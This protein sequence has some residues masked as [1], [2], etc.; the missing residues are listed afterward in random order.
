MSCRTYFQRNLL[1]SSATTLGV[2]CWMWCI[3]AAH[4][5][6]AA[7]Q[8]LAEVTNVSTGFGVPINQFA[9]VAGSHTL[10]ASQSLTAAVLAGATI[11]TN[12]PQL[13]I[14]PTYPADQQ[15]GVSNPPYMSNNLHNFQLS[16]FNNLFNFRG[17]HT[18]SS[19]DY[20]TVHGFGS[21]VEYYRNAGTVTWEPA[22]TRWMTAIEP[23]WDTLM[24]ALGLP[25]G[26]WD[27][28]VDTGETKVIQAVINAGYFNGLDPAIRDQLMIDME[29]WALDPTTLRQQ[30]WYPS[31]ASPADKAAFEKKYYDGYALTQYGPLDAAR[32]LGFKNISLYGWRPA[33]RNNDLAA[34]PKDP[35]ADWYWQNVGIQV[36]SH[37]D[38]IN[39]SV[40]VGDWSARN[41]AYTLALNDLNL[42]Y[43]KSLPTAQRK[44]LRPYFSNQIFSGT[45]AWRWFAGQGV[46]TEEMRAESLLNAFTQYDGMVLWNWSGTANDNLPPI[47]ATGID[48]MVKDGSF[49]AAREGG[50][51]QGFARYDALHVTNVDSSG[52][53][54]F[55]LIDKSSFPNYGTGAAFPFYDSTVTAM[56][57]HLRAQSEPLAGLFEGLAMAKLIEWNLRN[58]IPLV[59]FASQQTFDQQLPI[60]RHLTNGDLHIVATYDPQVVYGQPARNVTVNNFNAVAG[61]SLTF[62]ADSQVRLYFVKVPAATV[63]YW[64][65]DEGSGTTTADAS[66]N[67]NRGTLL[68]APAWTA[69]QTGNA[70]NFSASSSVAINGAGNLANLYKT[71]MTVAAWIKPGA[72]SAGGRIA[73]KDNNN[74]GWFFGMSNAKVQFVADQFIPDGSVAAAAASRVSAGSTTLNTWQHVVATWDGTTNA[75]NIHI[76]INGVLSDGAAVNGSGIADLD[77]ST[78]FTIGNRPVDLKRNFPG[79]IDEVRVYN[80]VLTQAQIQTLAQGGS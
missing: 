58:D 68:N 42:T 2:L 37:V 26:R 16:Y 75:S 48:V 32:Q 36:M 79:S 9:A 80:R 41:V 3:P 45:S 23:E 74:G 4:G 54:Q 52:N 76:Y 38:S 56:T 25:A 62:A 59:D 57:P 49:V 14:V 53:V 6:S 22:G 28:V 10:A 33:A 7:P 21:L 40:Y 61:L 20:A 39:S 69:G 11:Q 31:T 8:A 77:S 1:K 29:H 18:W 51:T 27:Q 50:G 15:D 44:P 17:Y 30:S 78:P 72:L 34:S 19:G 46:P 67:G 55:Q 13:G 65:L 60:L 12:P 70:L 71:G 43:V 5:Q 73:D 66:G 24:T 64:K 47:L 63:G 35:A